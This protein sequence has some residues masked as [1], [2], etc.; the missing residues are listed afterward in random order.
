MCSITTWSTLLSFR[1]SLNA[2]VE[3]T[4]TWEWGRH[5]GR[6]GS[7]AVLQQ[8]AL[9][10]A[11]ETAGG[12]APP[13]E[14]P[15]P[16]LLPL[17]KRRRAARETLARGAALIAS[18][19]ASSRPTP[20]RLTVRQLAPRIAQESAKSSTHRCATA[21][22]PK[23]ISVS[24]PG[25]GGATPLAWDPVHQISNGASRS[26]GAA[27]YLSR[28]ADGRKPFQGVVQRR[29]R[30][31]C[32]APCPATRLFAL[33]CATLPRRGIHFQEAHRSSVPKSVCPLPRR[34]KPLKRPRRCPPRCC[35]R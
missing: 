24:A 27:D 17:G 9:R 7:H 1:A 25:R 3:L 34:N 35:R 22:E 19:R 30:A 28:W 31:A 23:G 15:T 4:V 5:D 21:R 18:P 8:R 16:V 12:T 2:A 6:A 10:R 32:A 29:C 13:S 14:S 20:P 33:V 26:S 11:P